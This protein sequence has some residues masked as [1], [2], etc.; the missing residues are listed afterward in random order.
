[1]AARARLGRLKP[2]YF[3]LNRFIHGEVASIAAQHVAHNMGPQAVSRKH[4]L[5]IRAILGI[6]CD[7]RL[8][9]YHALTHSNSVDNPIHGVKH[10]VFISAPITAD[11][12][13]DRI[14]Q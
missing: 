10:D 4:E 13:A 11:S 1:M 5:R 6:G 8:P 3:G 12:R 14:D 7:L 9:R 2:V